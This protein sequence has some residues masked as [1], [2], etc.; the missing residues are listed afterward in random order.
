MNL[1]PADHAKNQD[2]DHNHYENGASV[3]MPFVLRLETA[4]V[5]RRIRLLRS[6]YTGPLTQSLG[7]LSFGLPESSHKN[8]VVGHAGLR[9]LA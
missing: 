1:E 4:P 9:I 7:R 3:F 6:R 5:N 2:E 8:A